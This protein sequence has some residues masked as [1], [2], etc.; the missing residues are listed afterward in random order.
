MRMQGW[1]LNL[2]RMFLPAVPGLREVDDVE[3]Q[4]ENTTEVDTF[5]AVVEDIGGLQ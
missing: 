5:A 2:V 1:R 4:D 3:G